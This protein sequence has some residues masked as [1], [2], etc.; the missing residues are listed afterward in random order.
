MRK[1]LVTKTSKQLCLL[2]CTTNE[3]VIVS[4][5]FHK[6]TLWPLFVDRVQLHAT[7]L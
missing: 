5:E 2:C 7:L 6:N 4:S 1:I 3:P